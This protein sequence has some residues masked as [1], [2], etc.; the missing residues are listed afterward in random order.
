MAARQK[1]LRASS[2]PQTLRWLDAGLPRSS[3]FRVKKTREAQ[4]IGKH[5]L[6]RGKNAD[7]FCQMVGGRFNCFLPGTKYQ[8]HHPREPPMVVDSLTGKGE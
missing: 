5:R 2:A 1:A 3:S 8:R 7:A 6:P 4:K